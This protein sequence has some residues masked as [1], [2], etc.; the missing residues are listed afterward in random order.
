MKICYI[1]DFERKADEGYIKIAK[2]VTEN[3]SKKNEI[4]TL[5]TNFIFSISGW[6]NLQKFK[7]EIIHYFSAP[8]L[9]SIVVL[10]I[11]KKMCYKKNPITIVSALHPYGFSFGKKKYAK[12]LMRITKPDMI[13]TQ[14]KESD[15]I[16]L[17]LGCKT[18]F[19][20]NGVDTHKFSP[21]SSEKKAIIRKKFGIEEKKFIALHV[22]HIIQKRGIDKLDLIQNF[23][24][25]IQVIIIGS[26][27][28]NTDTALLKKLEENNIIVINKY[29]NN[30]EEI[31]GMSDCYIFPVKKDNS[32]LM[33]LSILEAMSCNVAVISTRFPGIIENFEEGNGL[34]YYETDDELIQ[35]F[36]KT[37]QE[38]QEIYNRDKILNY[39]WNLIAQNLEEIYLKFSNKG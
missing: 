31:F 23:S 8:T 25:D 19:L 38:K 35:K 22:G 3:I 33:P 17:K 16:F 6:R 13:L 34:Y 32:I 15:L 29:F 27:Y 39:D 14:C 28:F 4:L 36:S 1:G 21:L 9:A 20:P 11:A 37:Y 24:D 30:I 12:Y 5:N 18:N 10:Y 26:S 7:P 2:C